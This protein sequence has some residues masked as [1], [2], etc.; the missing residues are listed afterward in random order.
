MLHFTG[1]HAGDGLGKLAA[2]LERAAIDGDRIH[3]SEF[4]AYDFEFMGITVGHFDIAL[5]VTDAGCDVR[6]GMPDEIEIQF[7]RYST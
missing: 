6:G 5:A 4:A 3:G 2:T 1:R 7:S